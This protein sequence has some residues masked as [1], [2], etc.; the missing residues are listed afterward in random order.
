MEKEIKCPYIIFKI[1]G[2]LYC[3]NSK[4]IS[5][6]LQLPEYSTIPAAPANITGMFKYRDKVINMMDLRITFGLK[7]ISE[8]CRDFEL[9]IDA[10]KQDHI[11]WVSELERFIKDGG[12][13][14]LARDPHQCALGKWY[15]H[16]TT[17]N[18]AVTN[19]LKKI[20]EPHEKL[21]KAAEEADNCKRD[22]QNC[23]ES[24]CLRKVLACAKDECMPVILKLLDQTKDLFRSTIYKEMVL[25]LDEIQWGIVVD[26]IVAV[27]DLEVISKRHEDP[28]I[29]HCSYLGRVMESEK[30]KGL[31]FELNPETL[32]AKFKDLES[33]F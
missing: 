2:S 15:D 20:E 13:F 23:Q 27:E 18:T 16:F 6:I 4:Y 21:H 26:E 5:T 28:M 17:D 7:P 10:R 19:H 31:I 1:A 25:I 24:E 8:E 33:M 3:I 9:M 30:Q 11:N 12:S 14:N 32:L 22:C 29:N